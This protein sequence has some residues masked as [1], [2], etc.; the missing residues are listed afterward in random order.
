MQS[1]RPKPGEDDLDQMAREF[2]A[3]KSK[4]GGGGVVNKGRGG[5]GRGG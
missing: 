3:E 2:E 4:G 5:Q 1:R